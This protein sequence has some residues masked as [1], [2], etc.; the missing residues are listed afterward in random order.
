M[1]LTAYKIYWDSGS[2][3]ADL[4]S[5]TLEKT[6]STSSSSYTKSSDLTA[7]VEYQFYVVAANQVG[8]SVPSSVITIMAADKPQ[9]PSVFTTVAQSVESITISWQE[10]DDG[11]DT[12]SDYEIDWNQG[13]TV[14][15]YDVLVT[16]TSGTRTHTIGSLTIPGEVYRFKVRSVNSIGTSVDSAEYQV[17]GASL[18]DAPI[19]FVRDET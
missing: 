7:G 3:S 15:S 11:G 6:L 17:I 18:P 10:P 5:F 13:D 4:S 1:S 2:G 8:D 19:S 14:N 16:T 9:P 12:I